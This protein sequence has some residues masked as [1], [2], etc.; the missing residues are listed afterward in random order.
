MAKPEAKKK[1]V[2]ISIA[3]K[4]APGG[5]VTIEELAPFKGTSRTMIYGDI[6]RGLLP[7]E[8]HGRNTRIAGPVARAY[9]PGRGLVS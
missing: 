8:K 5:F 7:V 2:E 9:V 4:L 6:K 1:P 3:D